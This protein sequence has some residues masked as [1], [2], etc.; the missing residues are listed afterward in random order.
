MMYTGPGSGPMLAAASAWESLA[1]EL[2]SSATAFQS[3]LSALTGA[4]QGQSA[5]TMAG[6]AEPYLS[7]IGNTAAQAQLAGAQASAAAAAFE[8][9]FG[10]TVPP[11]VIAANRALLMALIATNFFGQNSPAI[12][13]TEAAY[14]V[15]WA[16]DVLMLNTYAVVSSQLTQALEAFTAAPVVANAAMG[17]QSLATAA[18]APADSTTLHLDHRFTCCKV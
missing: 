10:S 17:T 16:D 2:G 14:D 3:S 13:A 8:T 12:A 18:A 6:A 9:A 5:T 7:W 11:P 4:W 15:M 1:G